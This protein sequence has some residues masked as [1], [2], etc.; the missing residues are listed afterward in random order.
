MWRGGR[1]G[2]TVKEVGISLSKFS[3]EASQLNLLVSF[4]INHTKIPLE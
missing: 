1:E 3:L 4:M 2:Q